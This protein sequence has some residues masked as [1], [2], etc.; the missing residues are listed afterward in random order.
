MRNKAAASSAWG[1][2]SSLPSSRV[3]PADELTSDELAP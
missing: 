3:V 2:G 1:T